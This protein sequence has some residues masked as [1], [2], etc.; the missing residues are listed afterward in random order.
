MRARAPRVRRRRVGSPLL[1]TLALAGSAACGPPVDLEASLQV[2][3]VTTGWFDEGIVNGQNKLVPSI[4]FTLANQSDQRISS[5]QL[6]VVFRRAGEADEWDAV[7]MQRAGSDGLEPGAT[8]GRL[9]VRAKLGYTGEQPRA[10]M[11]Q[12]PQFIDAR[13]RIFAKHGAAQWVEL[14]DFPIERRLLTR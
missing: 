3:D 14:G 9:V 5:V 6:N 12:H 11:L 7:Y 2:T 8:T 10:E 1:L 13:V 4:T